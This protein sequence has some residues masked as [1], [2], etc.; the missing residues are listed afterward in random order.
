MCRTRRRARPSFSCSHAV[1]GFVG[2][3]ASSKS[4]SRSWRSWT[5]GGRKPSWAKMS[6]KASWL[7]RGPDRCKWLGANSPKRGYAKRTPPPRRGRKTSRTTMNSVRQSRKYAVGAKKQAP[8]ACAKARIWHGRTKRRAAAEYVPRRACTSCAVT[9]CLLQM[10][11]AGALATPRSKSTSET[12][13]RG[14]PTMEPAEARR[15]QNRAT[16][17]RQARKVHWQKACNSRR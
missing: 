16:G 2:R 3:P 9:M 4:V 6:T 1:R 8:A 10:T 17:L 11:S 12:H 13:S 7:A 14:R 15:R 5:G